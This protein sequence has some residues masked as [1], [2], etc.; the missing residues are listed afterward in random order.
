MTATIPNA[1]YTLPLSIQ[2]K[3][4]VFDVATRIPTIIAAPPATLAAATTARPTDGGSGGGGGGA[5][6]NALFELVDLWPT[7]AELAGTTIPPQCPA[8]RDASLA[9][10]TCVEGAKCD[11]N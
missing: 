3:Y 2:A 9:T 8:S 10:I 4:Q 7:L 1:C 5:V 6:T 11:T